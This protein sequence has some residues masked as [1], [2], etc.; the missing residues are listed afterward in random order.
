MKRSTLDLLACPACRGDLRY[1]DTDGDML[2]LGSLVCRQCGAAYCLEDGIPRF[3]PANALSGF[4][5][6]FAHLYDWFSWVYPA[7]SRI[8]F[9][10]IGL[11]ERRARVDITGRLEPRG[12]RVLEISAGTGNNLPYLFERSDIGDVFALDISPGQLARCRR[13]VR[14]KGWDV[15]LQ[16]ADAERLPFKDNL[17]AGILHFGGINFFNDKSAAIREMIRVAQPGAR[18][19]VA[20]ETEK[21]AHSYEVILPFFKRSFRGRR[22]AVQAPVDLVPP[23][24]PDLR[25][26]EIWNGWAYRLEFTKP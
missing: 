22:P 6:R 1:Q 26:E 13:L 14:R 21:G 24:M 4:N 12:G 16:Q 15:E 10:V 9:R 7:F 23:G 2:V 19:V 8:A 5:R 25:L 3:A 11:S 17:F 20:D 18:I